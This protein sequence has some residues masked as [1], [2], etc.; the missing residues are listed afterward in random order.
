MPATTPLSVLDLSPISAGGSAARA[1]AD[2]LDLAVAVERAGYHRFW[3]AEHHLVPGVASSVPAVLVAAVAAR[4]SRLRVGSGAV[5]AGYRTALD[6]AEQ[7]GTL[8]ALHPDRIDLGLGR[9]GHRGGP[10]PAGSSSGSPDRVVDGLL[11]PEPF[12][13]SRLDP[14]RFGAVAALLQLPGAVP[15]PFGDQVRA[16]LDLLEGRGRAPDGQA[17]SAPAASAGRP[18]V[19]L[20]GSG[21]GESAQLAGQLGLP[22][23]ANYHVSPGTVLDAVEACRAAFRPGPV[24]RRPHVLVSA[25]VLAAPDA[26][27]ARELAEGFGLWVLGI[28]AGSGAP[29]YPSPAQAREH[30]WTDAEREVVRDRLATRFVGTPDDVV[31]RLRTLQRVTA[32]DELLLTTITYEHRHRVRS[33]ELLAQAWAA[34]RAAS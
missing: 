34:S 30:P 9:S 2:T 26:E 21:A 5:L 23:A 6:V 4:T 31:E 29:Q 32:A 8:A 10:P 1:L 24:L 7:F 13:L 28:R 14:K 18:Q 25:D 15:E 27:L 20:L 33:Y 12:P 22:F 17:V 16:I 11:L 3:V 19:W